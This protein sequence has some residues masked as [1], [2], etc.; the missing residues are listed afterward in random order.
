[1]PYNVK[2]NKLTELQ[3]K[4]AA[5]GEKPYKLGDGGGLSLLVLPAG[6]KY[7]HLCYFLDGVEKKTSL[8][9]YP[10]VKL[11]EAREARDAFRRDL[12]AGVNPKAPKT[13]VLTFEKAALAWH[14]ERILPS[15]SREYARDSLSMLS[16]FLFPSIG[17]RPIAAVTAAELLPVARS[18]EAHGHPA[19]ARKTLR[20]AG[21]VF[22]YAVALG[23]APGDPAGCL[24]GALT[25]YASG[26]RAAITDP[27]LA[28]R[29]FLAMRAFYGTA[30]VRAALWFSAYTFQRPGEIRRAEWSEMDFEEN[31]WRI[32]AAKMKKREPHLV[33]LS[34][35]ALEVLLTLRPL[36]GRGLYVFPSMR[37]PKGDAPMSGN[38]ITAAIRTLGFGKEEMCAHGFRGMASTILNENGFPPDVIERALAHTEGNPTRAAYNH[39][40]WL[41]QRREMMQWWADWVDGLSGDSSNGDSSNEKNS[42]GKRGKP[43][44]PVGKKPPSK[45]P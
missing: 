6:G 22:R 18:L 39:A 40:R 33:P 29:L 28:S 17:D 12:S 44:R 35:Q 9:V 36:T 32:P 14:A 37:T 45:T 3:V 1:M 42:N 30:T 15:K 24:K 10:Q 38:A 20:L 13:E 27:R 23:L 11:S 5:P 31:L 26:H 21:Q 4:N 7:W 34:R 16:R 43:L 8:G 25:P 2:T 41:P 19:A